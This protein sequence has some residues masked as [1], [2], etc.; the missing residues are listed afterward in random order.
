MITYT[1]LSLHLVAY[2]KKLAYSKIQWWCHAGKDIIELPE[3]PD[4]IR[5]EHVIHEAWN[6]FYLTRSKRVQVE[7]AVTHR[8]KNGVDQVLEMDDKLLD[9]LM[10]NLEINPTQ[11]VFNWN[12]EYFKTAACRQGEGRGR[13]RG[14]GRGLAY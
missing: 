12:R 6:M 8:S 13:G 5:L 9:D 4:W 14:R 2:I 7:I 3:I 10:T 1:D 11:V